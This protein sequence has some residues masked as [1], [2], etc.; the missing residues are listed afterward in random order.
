[1]SKEPAYATY[2]TIG[3]AMERETYG[4]Y[5]ENK[6]RYCEEAV[7]GFGLGGLDVKITDAEGETVGLAP[8]TFD[9][10]ATEYQPGHL[11]CV[12]SFTVAGFDS[13]SRFFTVEIDGIPGTQDLTR[14]ELLSGPSLS[15]TDTSQR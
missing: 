4:P 8:L 2:T 3:I 5:E 1:M 7:T 6:E 9:P 15:V 14:D 12:W 11:T 13:D 10:E